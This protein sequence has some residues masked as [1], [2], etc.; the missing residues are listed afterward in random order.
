MKYEVKYEVQLARDD[1]WRPAKNATL[2]SS[3][4]LCCQIGT[5]TH[6]WTIWPGRFR[7]VK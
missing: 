2:L 1:E 6:W 5:G 7:E 4:R 3:G